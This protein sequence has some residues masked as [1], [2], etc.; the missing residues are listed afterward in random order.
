MSENPVREEYAPNTIDM[1]GPNSP[2]LINLPEVPVYAP[3]ISAPVSVPAGVLTVLCTYPVPRAG[4]YL[5]CGSV[6]SASGLN[7]STISKLQMEISSSVWET[8]TYE[9]GIGATISQ[10][11]KTFFT[12]PRTLNI[13]DIVTLSMQQDSS[14]PMSINALL[15]LLRLGP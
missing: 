9:D 4:T 11:N 5:L 7:G 12:C 3:A 8:C 15:V 2:Q 10:Y 14:G 13:G 6:D 1:G